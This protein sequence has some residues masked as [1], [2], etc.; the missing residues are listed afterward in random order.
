MSASL[1]AAG[2]FYITPDSDLPVGLFDWNRDNGRALHTSR[3]YASWLLVVAMLPIL[4]LYMVWIPATYLG[5]IE[6]KNEKSYRSLSP[7]EKH[8]L[9]D[10]TDDDHMSASDDNSLSD[11]LLPVP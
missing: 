8:N 2:E 3:W 4:V 10:L 7:N 1:W 11:T 6:D 9:S 5:Y